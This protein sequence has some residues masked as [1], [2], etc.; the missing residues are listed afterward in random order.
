MKVTEQ[1]E[2]AGLKLSIQKTKI[3]ISGPIWGKIE[4]SDRFYFLG[5]QK[6]LQTVTAAM[7]EKM[8]ASWKESYDKSRQN[9]TKQRCHFANK[10][11]YSES[12][13]LYSSHVRVVNRY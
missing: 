7:N 9:I 6:S 3:M 5:F 4:S 12:Y 10:D 2:K 1:N 13:I 8:F 11:P